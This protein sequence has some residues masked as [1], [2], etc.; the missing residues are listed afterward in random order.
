M[1]ARNSDAGIGAA[2]VLLCVC[3]LTPLVATA[4]D[5]VDYSAPYL[6]VEDGKLVTKYPA[7]EHE[8]DPAQPA[9]ESE[10]TA[11]EAIE[12]AGSQRWLV[13]AVAAAAVLAGL[14]WLAR[15]R[16]RAL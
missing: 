9:A 7:Q 4:G 1:K 11:G 13:V 16:V 14:Y 3:A 8:G 12:P 6:V 2:A 5:D 15:R 10:A